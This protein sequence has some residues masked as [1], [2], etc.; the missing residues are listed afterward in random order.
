M[1]ATVGQTPESLAVLVFT[2]RG[3]LYGLLQESNATL[4]PWIQRY[5]APGSIPGTPSW[6][7]GLL[8]VQ[9]TVQPIVDL[10][11]F[12]GMEASTPT[13]ETR[14]IFV[15]RDELCVGLLVDAASSVRYFDT[16]APSRSHE[17]DRTTL[18]PTLL[19][20]TARLDENDIAILRAGDLMDVL[21]ALLE[22]SINAPFTVTA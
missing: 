9:G 4:Q 10:G 11:A 21:T 8:S 13:T 6:L 7:L 3:R 16:L 1:E 14:F 18:L 2:L 17:T 12:V 5:A 20:G 19:T 22:S 15:Q